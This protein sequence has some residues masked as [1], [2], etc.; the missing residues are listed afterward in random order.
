VRH[1]IRGQDERIM[2]WLD[3]APT[4][5]RGVAASVVRA[6]DRTGSVAQQPPTWAGAALVLAATGRRGGRAAVRGSV[7]YAITGLVAN[8]LVKPLVA[9]RRPPPARRKLIG[10]VTTSFPSGHGATDVAFVFGASQELPASFLPLGALATVAHWSLVRSGGHYPSDVVAGGF[11]G[12][13]V[14]LLTRRFWP[15]ATA[16]EAGEDDA[17]GETGA[18]VAPF[19]EARGAPGFT[20]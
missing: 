18:R 12:L 10:P 8:V 19:P 13:A 11:V 7:C 2:G 6:L 15:P 9:R 16:D 3:Q 5:R 1:A 4:G 14:A 17:N 20:S